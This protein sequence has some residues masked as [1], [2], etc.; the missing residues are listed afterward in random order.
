MSHNRRHPSNI[1]SFC[2]TYDET[3]HITRLQSPHTRSFCD[4]VGGM[5]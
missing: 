2:D 3:S 4:T 5:S 1:H